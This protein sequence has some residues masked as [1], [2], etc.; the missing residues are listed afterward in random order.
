MVVCVAARNAVSGPRRCRCAVGSPA[1][2]VVGRALQHFWS[3]NANDPAALS[4]PPRH[5]AL[6]CGRPRRRELAEAAPEAVLR[7]TPGRRHRCLAYR[8]PWVRLRRAV[9]AVGPPRSRG[10]ASG[11][12]GGPAARG[13]AFHVALRVGEWTVSV[14]RPC[15]VAGREGVVGIRVRSRGGVLGLASNKRVKLTVAQSRPVRG[16]GRAR[17]PT[18]A[19]AC[20]LRESLGAS[21]HADERFSPCKLS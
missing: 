12:R 17:P 3:R 9:F 19:R 10:L 20:S 4:Q 8:T 13:R 1:N 7:G 11:Q 5:G 2:G 16:T 21:E 18:A 6:W 15:C 14:R